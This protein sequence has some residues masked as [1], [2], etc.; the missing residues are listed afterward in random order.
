MFTFPN[1]AFAFRFAGE[2]VVGW[3][4]GALSLSALPEELLNNHKILCIVM[5]YAVAL[6]T[7]T[8][9]VYNNIHHVRYVIAHTIYVYTP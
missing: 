2:I 5:P 3:L 9:H 6:G 4:F 8:V 7:H 1:I